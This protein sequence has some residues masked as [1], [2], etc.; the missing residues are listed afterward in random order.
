MSDKFD[1]MAREMMDGAGA[2]IPRAAAAQLVAHKL[3]EVVERERLRCLYLVK[4][5]A[6]AAARSETADKDTIDGLL[7]LG[8]EVQTT[9]DEVTPDDIASVR[10]WKPR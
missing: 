6:D 4:Y 9:I 5:Y 8:H 2:L 3:R 1:D 7:D 10:E